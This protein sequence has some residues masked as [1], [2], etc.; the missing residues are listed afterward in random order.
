MSGGRKGCVERLVMRYSN[1]DN[2]KCIFITGAASGIG[3]ASA[4][5][6]A[7][8]GWYV[9][10][11][12]VDLEELT[13]L[14]EEI[15]EDGCCFDEVDVTQM[16]D[17]QHAIKIF[18]E[19]TDRQMDVL[20]NNAGIYRV[21]YFESMDIG[22][23]RR[24]IDVNLMGVLNCTHAAF[25]MLKQTPGARVINM[26]S[27]SAIYGIPEIAAYSCSKFAVRGLTEALNIEFERHD[28]TVS[29]IMVGFVQTPLLDKTAVSVALEKSGAKVTAEQVA[30]T[31]WKAA[32]GRKVHWKIGLKAAMFLISLAPYVTRRLVKMAFWKDPSS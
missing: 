27:A 19:R 26:S 4:L 17:I 31:V 28:I 3:R 8:Q 11:F 20:F 16:V 25:E 24:I 1:M 15:G 9:G 18:G 21:G 2:R 12:D 30:K 22:E 23:Q 7:Q 5:Y 10:L 13:K 14:A 29:D 6:F 32:H